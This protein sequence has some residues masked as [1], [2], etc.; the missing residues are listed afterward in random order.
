M[1]PTRGFHTQRNTDY[2][3]RR[4][5]SSSSDLLQ[6]KL[7]KLLNDQGP[8]QSA[9]LSIFQPVEPFDVPSQHHRSVNST[10]AGAKYRNVSQGLSPKR[11]NPEVY[12]IFAIKQSVSI[13]P[14]YV[15]NVLNMSE[16]KHFAPICSTVLSKKSRLLILISDYNSIAT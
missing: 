13:Y 5:V 6:N 11:K 4:S 9:P 12:N 3:N 2:I 7:R 1:S 16:L 10:A 15:H 14:N 8:N